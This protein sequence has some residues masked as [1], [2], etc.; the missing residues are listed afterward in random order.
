MPDFVGCPPA[1]IKKRGNQVVICPKFRHP[2]LLPHQ[3]PNI[4][5]AGYATLG[6]G[7]WPHPLDPRCLV[8]SWPCI[9]ERLGRS[10]HP[11]RI[12]A[13]EPPQLAVIEAMPGSSSVRL[14]RPAVH[15]HKYACSRSSPPVVNLFRNTFLCCRLLHRSLEVDVRSPPGAGCR[16]VFDA[17]N[18][19]QEWVHWRHNDLSSIAHRHDGTGGCREWFDSRSTLTARFYPPP[20][21]HTTSIL[22]YLCGVGSDRFGNRC[23]CFASPKTHEFS[24]LIAHLAVAIGHP[25]PPD[26]HTLT[27]A[28]PA[29]VA[30]HASLLKGQAERVCC[31]TRYYHRR[32]A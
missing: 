10:P 11:H 4:G 29:P 9:H 19:E 13:T 1:L 32:A 24:I 20:P 26:Q 2:A 8:V 22:G 6:A 30:D 17:P 25:R 28:G 15:R 18:R 3:P 23:D 16:T 12:P 31:E 5:R 14:P 7:L 27:G 21:D